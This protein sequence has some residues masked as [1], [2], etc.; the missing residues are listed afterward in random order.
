M[1]SLWLQLSI[2]TFGILFL[3]A[4]CTQEP[5][6]TKKIRHRDR[7]IEYF[8]KGE[9][10]EA[11]V[12][13]KN[14]V[15][16]APNDA[17]AHYRMALTYLKLGSPIDL[18]QAFKELSATVELDA[19]N[20]D[21]QL[22]L[23]QLLLLG[24]EPAQ[25]RKRAGLVLTASPDNKE[26]IILLGASLISEEK[27]QEG[28]AELKKAI[29]LDPHNINVYLDLARAYVHIK[30]FA[31]AESVLQQALQ[32]NP[33]SIE[34]RLALG[35]LHLIRGKADLAE[36]EYKRAVSDAPE[37]PETNIK[38]GTFYLSTNRVADAEATYS[39]WAQSRPQD[40]VPL[41][42]LGDFYRYTGALDRAL[43]SYQH[44]LAIN[45][46][47]LAARDRQIAFLIDTSKLEEAEQ[48][49]AAI[50][51]ANSNDRSGRLFD[52]RLKLARGQHDK[53]LQLL[54]Q[55]SREEP[56]SPTVHHFLGVAYGMTNDF[57]QAA[58]E[59]AEAIKYAPNSYES[60]VALAAL[61]LAQGLDNEAIEQAQIA[62]RL[63]PRNVQPAM[64]LGEAYLHKS[65]AAK[66]GQVFEAITKALPNQKVAHHRL[67]LI[68]RFQK[69]DGEALAHFEQALKADPEFMDPLAQIIAIR[70][71][72]GKPAE[73]LDRIK[74]HQELAPK[75][76][77]IYTLL[78]QF[79]TSTKEYDRAEVAF[80]QAIELND[81]LL[82]AYTGLA[83]LYV[84]T[85]RFDEAIREYE[86]VLAKNPKLVAPHMILGIIFESRKQYDQAQAR[87]EEALRI[88]PRFAP[89]ANNLAWLLVERGGNMDVALGYAQTARQVLPNDPQIADTL[90][91]IFYKKNVYL[92]ALSLL[93]EA[94]D[95]LP[96]NPLVLYHYGM[97]LYKNDKKS[98]ARPVLEKSLR[99]NAAHPGATEAKTA[100]AELA[101]AS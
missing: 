45:P 2:V 33:R 21:A 48:Q 28:I 43:T 76:P 13:F 100:L 5:A 12:E 15:Q 85:K 9:Y 59:L 86:T 98:D 8:N 30:D 37:R 47:S 63:N 14:V 95:K 78:G 22:K 26:G 83:G 101:S 41:V 68:A 18:E 40:D 6:E 80:K 10:R 54:Q 69:Q 23:G 75:N 97:A 31:S 36:A 51:K 62:L 25:A 73:A 20:Y 74:R 67:G 81:S 60:R 92:K 1:K 82:E 11:L 71:A 88:T 84:Q 44:A 46:K 32:N 50:L 19:G 16:I 3:A 65:D 64:I 38:L 29:D 93:K 96:D 58:S 35:D 56:R 61:Q 53:A 99:L 42:T 7:A 39:A 91:W 34:A 17:D 70:L 24:K 52:A 79:F 49:T 57:S 87:Y 55:L 94:A 89:A 77:L 72:Q 66:A 27:F 4:S 90:G